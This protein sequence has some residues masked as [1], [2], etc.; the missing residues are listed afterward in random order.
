[1][2]GKS[3]TNGA[4]DLEELYPFL[5]A[6]EEDRLANLLAEVGASTEDKAREIVSLR[7]SSVAMLSERMLDCAD[8]AARA[9][10]AGARLFCFGNGGSAT[11][12]H[13]IAHSY[14]NPAWGL[15]LPAISLAA[16]TAV[17]TALGND[18]GF[19]VVFAR[20]LAALGSAGDMALGLSTSGNSRNLLSA[21]E[22]A[23]RRGMMTIG[24]AGYDGGKMAEAGTIDFLFIVPSSS[25]HRI[26]EVQ[27]TIYHMLWEATQAFLGA[28]G[29]T[30]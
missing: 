10:T 30:P 17:I 13:A 3:E 20:Q 11:D 9:F 23:N 27:T 16:D 22:E 15:P 18:V 6:K 8:A 1:M 12:A 2:S 4:A 26:Q 28:A 5:Y 14:L 21:F 25:V 29:D 24:I 19:E 7:R